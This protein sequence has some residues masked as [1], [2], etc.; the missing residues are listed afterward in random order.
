MATIPPHPRLNDVSNAALFRELTADNFTILAEESAKRLATYQN[1]NPTTI[2]GPP[3][4]GTRALNEFWR[5]ALGGEW[6]CTFAGTPGTWKQAKPAAVTAD[7]SSGTIPTGYLVWNVTDG[8]VK[9]HAGSYSWEITVGASASAK[10]GFHGAASTA[11]RTGAAQSAVTY[12]SQTISDPPTRAQVQAINDGL[13]AA[14]TLLNELRAAAVEKG[15]IK[16]GP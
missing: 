11:Q 3:T 6:V 1:G 7:P 16:G 10:V 12:V 5:D 13:V 9:R 14:I 2:I 4:T 15:L 8:A